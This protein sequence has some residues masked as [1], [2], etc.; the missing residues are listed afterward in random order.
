M[1]RAEMLS[2]WLTVVTQRS[3]LGLSGTLTCRSGVG[4]V[5]SSGFTGS[6]VGFALLPRISFQ[7]TK[8]LVKDVRDKK[9]CFYTY[10][11]LMK[12]PEVKK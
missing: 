10:S 12:L 11:N 2:A 4:L 7:H 6:R 9:G 1:K 5:A 8:K 3:C